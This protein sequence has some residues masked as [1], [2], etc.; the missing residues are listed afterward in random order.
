M[1]G[2]ETKFHHI[3]WAYQNSPG[4]PI[5]SRD[6]RR[7]LY[8]LY[9]QATAGDAQGDYPSFFKFDER[10]KFSAWRTHRG[11]SREEAMRRYVELAE[12]LG[13]RDP[14]PSPVPWIS[15]ETWR[16]DESWRPE[17]QETYPFVVD[18]VVQEASELDRARAPRIATSERHEK[19][20]TG[21]PEEQTERLVEESP[22]TY[23]LRLIEPTWPLCC[24]RLT[25]LVGRWTCDEVFCP[26][27]PDVY[28]LGAGPDDRPFDD[29]A[30]HDEEK[31]F[32]CLDCGRVYM[33]P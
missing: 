33:T 1:T 26:V 22:Q 13:Y 19:P 15:D 31:L 8:G 28:L 29:G 23:I 16:R 17:D 12:E 6:A 3:A 24:R 21:S 7:R 9:K 32:H 25:T 11:M 2:I 14:G 4:G 20:P 30:I 5:T 27:L 10:A 18:P